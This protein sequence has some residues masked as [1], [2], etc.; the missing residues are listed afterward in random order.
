[1]SQGTDVFEYIA[2]HLILE[3]LAFAFPGKRFGLP[4]IGCGLA[5]GE[6]ETIIDMIEVFA[7]R[8]ALEGGNVTLVK[9]G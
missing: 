4:Y 5:G 9:F 7:G 1:M 2:F 8:I 3:K 6:Q